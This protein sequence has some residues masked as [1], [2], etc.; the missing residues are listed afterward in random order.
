MLVFS[1]LI[2]VC[3]FDISIWKLQV[4]IRAHLV[5]FLTFHRNFSCYTFLYPSIPESN[6][7]VPRYS[8]CS[9]HV[10][11]SQKTEPNKLGFVLG[12]FG[13]ED[14]HWAKIC[15]SRPVFCMWDAVTSW[16]NEQCACLHPGSEP[17]NP[18]SP[19]QSEQTYP[20]HYWAGPT[21]NTLNFI[22]SESFCLY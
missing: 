14:C 12:F 4:Y 19:K 22:F 9:G 11:T 3:F 16:L 7:R 17:V 2:F 5:Q 15:V 20:L 13:E 8:I 6:T 21:I 18:R 1:F 10:R